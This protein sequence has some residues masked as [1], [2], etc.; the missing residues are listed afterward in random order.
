MQSDV[1]PKNSGTDTGR[2]ESCR[3]DEAR[4][5]L[6][7]ARLAALLARPPLTVT[8]WVVALMSLGA[9]ALHLPERVSREDFSSYYASAWTLRAGGNPYI[10]DLDPAANRLGLHLGLLKRAAYTP[11]FILCFEPLTRSPRS[12]PTEKRSFTAIG[13]PLKKGMLPWRKWIVYGNS[14]GWVI[15]LG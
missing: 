10:R 15:F 4:Q 9:L 2:P 5:S 14:V 1:R 8:L 11:T 7:L 12:Q 13:Q 3:D 6:P